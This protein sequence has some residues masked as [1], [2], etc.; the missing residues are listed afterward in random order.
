MKAAE[1]QNPTVKCDSCDWRQEVASVDAIRDWHNKN[2]PECGEGPIVNDDELA[3]LNSTV[4]LID[5]VNTLIGDVS[6]D[7]KFVSVNFDTA[8]MR[9]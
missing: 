2:C 9:K 1:I 8:P 6:E 3:V 7:E 5:L 4:G